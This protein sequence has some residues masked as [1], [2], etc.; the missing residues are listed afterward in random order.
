MAKKEERFIVVHKEGTEYDDLGKR[1]VMLDQATGVYYLVLAGANGASA[2]TPLLDENG[3]PMLYDPD[4]W[5]R[6]DG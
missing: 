5:N 3:K 4:W 1:M 6:T 2:L